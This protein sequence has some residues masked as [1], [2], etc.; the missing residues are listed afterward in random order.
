[1]NFKDTWLII[2]MDETPVYLDMFS[3]TTIDFV[4]A[5]NVSIVTTGREKYRLTVLLSIC[6][7]GWKLPP[8]VVVKGESGK[9]NENKLRKLDFVRKSKSLFTLKNQDGAQMKLWKSG[10]KKFIPLIRNGVKKKF[11]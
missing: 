7:N 1:M 10:S 3:D 8:L 9:T 5:E 2:N 11:Y 4:G 6:A